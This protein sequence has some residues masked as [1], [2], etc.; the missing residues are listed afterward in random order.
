[1]TI[2]WDDHTVQR[3][4]DEMVQR[5]QAWQR[6]QQEHGPFLTAHTFVRHQ[7]PEVHELDQ[8]EERYRAL[9]AAQQAYYNSR[10]RFLEAAGVR[11]T[12]PP[13]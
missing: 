4:Y 8:W 12:P 6:A 5:G 11:P 3:A 1:M 7:P 2:D 13:A 9:N 10:Q